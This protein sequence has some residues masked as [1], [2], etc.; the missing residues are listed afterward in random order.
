MVRSI[1]LVGGLLAIALA[2]MTAAT[3]AFA[4]ATVTAQNVWARATPP[5]AGTA[6]VFLTLK[7]PTDDTLTGISTPVAATA[8]VHETTMTD[9]IMRMRPVQGGLKLPAGQTVTL[10]PGSYHIMLEGLKRPLKQGE[11][12]PLHLTFKTAPPA[13]VTA[14]VESIGAAGYAAPG[15]ASPEMAPSAK[16]AP[17]MKMSP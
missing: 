5:R 9:G 4:Q 7:S 16:M 11:D 15:T 13:D 12:V 14:H 8:T 6:A 3:G 2:G 17:G 10:Q 1:H